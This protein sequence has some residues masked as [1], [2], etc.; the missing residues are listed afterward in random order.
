[1]I[2]VMRQEFRGSDLH[3]TK[4]PVMI[5]NHPF[6]IHD[7]KQA[8][9]LLAQKMIRNKNSDAVIFGVPHGGA[10]IGYHLAKKLNLGFDVIPC[11]PIPHPADQRRTIGSVSVDQVVVHDEGYDIPRDYIYHQIMRSQ[12]V[13]DAQQ[14][15][16]Q[17]A[18]PAEV[19]VR[20]KDVIVAGDIVKSADSLLAAIRALR[21]RK[22][23]K[24]IVAAPVMTPEAMVRLSG[25][26]DE[27]VCLFTE[28]SIPS[29]GFYEEATI[30]RDEDVKDLLR[31][32][33][34]AEA[35]F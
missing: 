7:R 32:S 23:G 14:A 30:I 19:A 24:V 29:G 8:A 27:I 10:V 15:F 21:K 6:T 22:P 5:L 4:L 28:D 13:L 20:N 17:S 1:M 25:E 35:I 33:A 34:K 26:V 11:R 18:R 12:N 2:D 9:L 31:R 3:S 16:Y